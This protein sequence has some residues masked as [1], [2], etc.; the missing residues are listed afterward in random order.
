MFPLLPTD[1]FRLIQSFLRCIVS[2][3]GF[4]NLL[5]TCKLFEAVKYE[6]V[7]LRFSS[8]NADCLSYLSVIS[9]FINNLSQ[10]RNQLSV[11]IGPVLFNSFSIKSLSLAV[12]SVV[13]SQGLLELQFNAICFPKTISCSFRNIRQ[14]IFRNCKGIKFDRLEAVERLDLI[15]MEDLVDASDI[16]R[17]TGLKSITISFCSN[18]VNISALHGINKVKILNCESVTSFS[19]LGDH[20]SFTFDCIEF[21]HNCQDVSM[22]QDIDDIVITSDLAHC[23]LSILQQVKERLVL[24]SDQQSECEF[25][26]F[27]GKEL[28]L[29][30]FHLRL[31]TNSFFLNCPYL[32]YLELCHCTSIDFQPLADLKHH[33]RKTLI[34]VRLTSCGE[35]SNVSTLGFVPV[36]HIDRCGPINSLEGLGGLKGN[37]DLFLRGINA[38][39][40]TPLRGIDKVLLSSYD[41][42]SLGVSALENIRHL[43]IYYG[44]FSEAVSVNNI[45]R[46]EIYRCQKLKSLGGLTKIRMLLL[47][48]C[49]SLEDI[50]NLG[51]IAE[52][53]FVKIVTCPIIRSLYNGNRY[54]ETLMKS[55]TS[56]IIEK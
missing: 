56:F 46:L 41:F 33:L 28:S 45:R 53:K 4:A 31:L 55:I 48:N 26:S 32:Q 23:D 39:D 36:L 29:T 38:S 8:K 44:S 52:L 11:E 47:D 6:T 5:N 35:L 25:E 24:H 1:I 20:K 40:L 12:C 50:D 54:K 15:S 9:Y 17:I 51:N 18:L 34:R 37:K 19:G 10:P 43:K 14:L 49:H 21:G 16:R 2:N 7:Q 3:Q 27:S 42:V 13:L 22:F 30:N